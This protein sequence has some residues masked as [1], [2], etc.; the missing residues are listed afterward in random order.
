M[1]ISLND[2]FIK[3]CAFSSVFETI[4][5]PMV[6]IASLSKNKTQIVLDT[7]AGANCINPKFLEDKNVQLL[8]EYLFP[9]SLKIQ[10]GNL[11]TTNITKAVLVEMKTTNNKALF[12]FLVVEHLPMN[13][14]I[15]RPSA[16]KEFIHYDQEGQIWWHNELLQSEKLKDSDI[17]I[18]SILNEKLEE[19]DERTNPPQPTIT[20][21]R[22]KIKPYTLQSVQ[23]KLVN[24]ENQ[25]TDEAFF[26]PN[27]EIVANLVIL[28]G[29]IN[30][31]EQT[32]E[33]T[34]LVQN[35]TGRPKS[36][37][38][39]ICL[40]TSYFITEQDAEETELFEMGD[41]SITQ[42]TQM[43]KEKQKQMPQEKK[44]VKRKLKRRLKAKNV[45]ISVS[46]VYLD[47][48]VEIEAFI[49]KRNDNETVNPITLPQLFGETKEFCKGFLKAETDQMKKNKEVFNEPLNAAAVLTMNMKEKKQN[50]PPV[51]TTK[52]KVYDAFNLKDSDLD[53]EQIDQL[54]N[55]LLEFDN[56][57]DAD[58]KPNEIVHTD[59]VQCPIKTTGNPIRQKPHRTNPVERKIIQNH[60]S[61]MAERKVIRKST[62][63][64]ASPVI[65]A[66]KKNG[67]VRFCIDYRKLN[68]VT[69][70]NA[71]PLP[72]MDQILEILGKSSYYSTI[73]LTDA[74]WSI[75]VKDE[76][77]F[78]TA[79]ISSEGL[80]E[81]ISMPF[82][83]TNAPATQQ[84]FIETVLNG[85]IWECCFAYIDDILCFS[86]TFENHLKDLRKIFTRLKEH[87][88]FLQPP[89]C[90]FCQST[91]EILGL[92]SSQDGIQPSQSK[93]KAI[94]DFP[95]PR[96]LK[97]AQSFMGM[98]SWLRKFIH[99]CSQRTT[100]LRQCMSNGREKFQ[101]NQEA[102]DEIDKLKKLVT[103]YP[104]LA[105]PNLEKQFYIHVDASALG[106]GAIL[107]QEDENGRHR[108]IEYAS[109]LIQN[110]KLTNTEREAF[111]ILW[112]L[113]H[114]RYYVLG[115]DP[116]VY[117]DCKC[118]AQIFRSG[119][120]PTTASLR[121]WVARLLHYNPK[122]LHRPGSTMA[123]PDA[124]SRAHIIE[125]GPEKNDPA[126]K[127]LGSIF[128]TA[129]TLK[130]DEQQSLM[131]QAELRKSANLQPGQDVFGDTGR[132]RLLMLPA[133]VKESNSNGGNIDQDIVMDNDL[134][135]AQ[136]LD[137]Y[138]NEIIEYKQF[139][140]LPQTRSRAAFVKTSS[141]MYKIDDRG[142]LR[143]LYTLKKGSMDD[144]PPAVL[145]AA[146]YDEVLKH[147]HDEKHSGH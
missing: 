134:A 1:N 146:L 86:D 52:K 71:Y 76:D 138:W 5:R 39:K 23:V 25:F 92:Q 9:K 42:T 115:R 112:A 58:K 22:Q 102:K 13:A 124:L 82:G 89:K 49:Q 139:H 18:Y 16:V 59:T 29:L 35:L 108:V 96:T 98:I 63:P 88:L 117:C 101:L 41:K 85:L 126:E 141:H 53:N 113:N 91:F 80:W 50:L 67:K 32:K 120:M 140:K 75:K 65:L 93:V 64:W 19:K 43:F 127:L 122:V 83:L 84:Q 99:G 60:V 100:H 145:P 131:K 95:Y 73:D 125:Y 70:K 31:D 44:T 104:C 128:N 8:S 110:K 27:K 40:G 68:N 142:I 109:H 121:N 36:I 17:S 55:L 94:E 26:M 51:E 135:Y 21:K 123:I 143:R 12:W 34:I 78:K 14:L 15:G 62:S 45:Q 28:P 2:P 114:F 97:E 69:V 56:V 38:D 144:S 11:Q 118:L 24:E 46:K 90:F 66:D 129:Y 103:Q 6:F 37:P 107:T 72:R 111:G 7:G 3:I 133:L 54:I 77:I 119:K 57:W 20:V 48:L 147:F 79:F 132:I 130:N 74:F 106:I 136:R 10:V 33:A 116:I 87:K 30:F 4:G 105:H 61:K 47:K 81:F 137:P